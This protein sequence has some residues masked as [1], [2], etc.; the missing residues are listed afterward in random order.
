MCKISC[1]K[2]DLMIITIKKYIPI[3]HEQKR[4]S[5][6]KFCDTLNLLNQG[7][8]QLQSALKG[9]NHAKESDSEDLRYPPC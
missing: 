9:T 7:N 2:I 4:A 5:L 3:E 8:V 6:L 1:L